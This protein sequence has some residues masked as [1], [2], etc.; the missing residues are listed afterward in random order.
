MKIVAERGL[1]LRLKNSLRSTKELAFGG[2]EVT[3]ESSAAFVEAMETSRPSLAFP[4]LSQ[5]GR[6]AN[7]KPEQI[8]PPPQQLP[9]HFSPVPS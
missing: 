1:R 8:L 5:G 9:E 4:W 2:E 6:T 7:N 3:R